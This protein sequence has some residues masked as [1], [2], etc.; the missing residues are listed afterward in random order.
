MKYKLL[1]ILFPL[2]VAVLCPGCDVVAIGLLAS[3]NAGS[4]ESG[5]SGWPIEDEPLFERGIAPKPLSEPFDFQIE[6]DW[7][8][9]AAYCAHVDEIFDQTD[10]AKWEEEIDAVCEKDLYY[11]NGWSRLGCLMDGVERRIISDQSIEPDRFLNHLKEWEKLSPDSNARSL[12]LVTALIKRAWK[13]RT[14]ALAY[15]V[16]EAQWEGFFKYL[17]QA[18]AVVHGLRRKGFDNPELYANMITIGMGLG[19]SKSAT[20]ETFGESL[21]CAP[22][23]RGTYTALATSFQEKWGGSF[24]DYPQI[25][26]FA[27]QEASGRVGYSAGYYAL[28]YIISCGTN[29]FEIAGSLKWNAL[30]DGYAHSLLFFPESGYGLN[31]ICQLACAFEELDDARLYFERI[32]EQGDTD[33][34]PPEAFNDWRDWACGGAVMPASQPIHEAAKRNDT[35]AIR[36]ELEKG[37]PVDIRDHMGR[38]PLMVAPYE[39]DWAAINFLLEHGANP[40]ARVKGWP[41]IVQSVKNEDIESLSSLIKRGVNP[42]STLKNGTTALHKAA[43]LDVPEAI[44]VLLSAPNIEI[45]LMDAYGAT[46][47]E[48]ASDR[49]YYEC[50]KLLIDGGAS[51]AGGN[52]THYPPLVAATDKKHTEIAKLLLERGADPNLRH[53]GGWCALTAAVDT[54][55]MELVELFL[56]SGADINF[57][58]DTGWTA[59]HMAA[60]NGNLPML[61][62]LMQVPGANT[63]PVAD[64][65]RTLLHQAVKSDHLDILKYLLDS[66]HMPDIADGKGRTALAY[67]LELGRTR[68]VEYLSTVEATGTATAAK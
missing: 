36:R 58:D 53:S 64:E 9:C 50:A 23:Y 47:L 16:T 31:H 3:L 25:V 4:P 61:K 34:W 65:G 17:N 10:Y 62:R 28:H 68:L 38:T 57:A 52:Q 51:L 6:P 37:T 67:A 55:N 49:G 29:P 60:M 24:S 2:C 66:V 54:D 11:A 43:A 5:D 56:E 40:E 30:R 33:V 42:N 1:G 13:E 7:E 39:E 26:D 12:V 48:I 8:A 22:F 21:R 44:E 32:G 41:L 46:P 19:E 63:Q 59:M 20:L 27:I 35:E 15:K 45:D 18:Q 14:S